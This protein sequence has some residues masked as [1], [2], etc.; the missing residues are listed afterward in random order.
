MKQAT[1]HDSNAADTDAHLLFVGYNF[2]TPGPGTVVVEPVR[3][4]LSTLYD[5]ENGVQHSPDGFQCG[6]GGAG[7]NQLAFAL[8]ARVYDTETAH[9]HYRAYCKRVVARLPTDGDTD[10]SDLLS[11]GETRE[12]TPDWKLDEA[13]VREFIN[14]R[15][16]PARD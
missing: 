10:G 12:M 15:T 9:D 11:P 4:L 13:S 3:E 14:E 2:G 1:R 5:H 8:I 7:P 16:A 6:Y